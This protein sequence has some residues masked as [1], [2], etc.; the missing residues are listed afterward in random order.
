MSN[1][2]K[3][4]YGLRKGAIV[5][6][7]V[8]EKGLACGCVCPA[9]DEPLIANHGMSIKQPYFSHQSGRE[10]EAAYQTALHLLAKEVLAAEKRILLPPL[11]VVVQ[12]QLV[13]DAQRHI[14]SL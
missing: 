11:S 14:E 10:C 9:C 13:Q 3:N 2:L 4:P 12:D 6:P 7:D 5:T 1:V 8:V